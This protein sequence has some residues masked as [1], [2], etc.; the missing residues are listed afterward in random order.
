MMQVSSPD[1]RE[2]HDEADDRRRIDAE[3]KC[4]VGAIIRYRH[5]G[6]HGSDDAEA[7]KAGLP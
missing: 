5:P 4:R 3:L 7:G 1:I 6:R 2:S